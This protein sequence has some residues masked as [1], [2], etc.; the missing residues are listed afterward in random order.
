MSITVFDEKESVFFVGGPGTQADAAADNGGGCSKAWWDSE[1]P[2]K[3]QPEF[4]AAYAKL[5]DDDGGPI[6]SL[7]DCSYAHLDDTIAKTG[8]HIGV[9]VG[10]V[11]YVIEQPTPDTDVATGRYEITAVGTDVITCAG[12]NGTD[13]A[14]VDVRIGGALDTLETALDETDASSFDVT[15]HNNLDEDLAGTI[16]GSIGGSALKNTFKRVIGFNIIPGDMS[17]GK[18]YYQSPLDALINGV[19]ESK[20]VK[21]DRNG[22]SAILTISADNF[23]FENFN[24]VG[25]TGFPAIQF[26]TTPEHLVFKNCKSS[27][28][29]RVS[30]GE[31]NYVMFDRVFTDQASLHTY[32]IT[33]IGNLFT[34]CIWNQAALKNCVNLAYTAAFINCIFIGGKFGINIVGTA[35]PVVN[36]CVFYNIGTYPL[37]LSAGT[38]G[39][40]V[41]N[42][43]FM[44]PAGIP[45]IKIGVSGGSVIYEDYNCFIKIDGGLIDP[46]I[47]TDYAGGNNSEIGLHSIEVDPLFVDAANGDFRL[48]PE[49]S[50]LMTG[51][52]TVDGYMSMGAWQRVSRIRR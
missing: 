16:T 48:L 25:A 15:I 42:S 40:S 24:L 3:T 19:D 43:I 14:L 27:G 35:L 6:I 23:V 33:G 32:I 44:L 2:N 49:S 20:S 18:A 26:N 8:I 30:E 36:N 39:C 4:A 7:D 29:G 31:A 11:A 38:G 12:I 45:A 41:Y 37:F 51:K 52:P 9:E 46:I 50:C 17:V 28:C 22:A 34:G 13:T 47:D 21:L 1:C 5:M 10:M